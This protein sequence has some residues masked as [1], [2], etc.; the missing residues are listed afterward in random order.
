M[1]DMPVVS[2]RL[3]ED[4]VR[5]FK[6]RN[7]RVGTVA[8]QLLEERATM[9]QAQEDVEWLTRNA[10]RSQQSVVEGLREDRDAH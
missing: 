2:V 10:I 6:K 5:L 9:L 7:L 1:Y 3:S 8:R 4:I